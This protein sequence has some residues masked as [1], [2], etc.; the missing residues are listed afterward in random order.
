MG[1]LDKINSIFNA[2]IDSVKTKEDL[3]NIKTEFLEKKG[4]IT[5]QFQTLGSLDPER[6]ERVC[7]LFK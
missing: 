2:K 6:K 5:K 7:L 1:N 3:Q 4:Q